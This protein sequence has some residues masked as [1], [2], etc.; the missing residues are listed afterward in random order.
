MHVQKIIKKHRT[1]NTALNDLQ[2]VKKNHPCKQGFNP[3][4]D[5]GGIFT[6]PNELSQISK[7]LRRP[8]ACDFLYVTKI[9]PR[10]P[11]KI[12]A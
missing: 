7:K 6:P 4:L 12:S 5:G 8:K 1:C 2:I 10:H 9:S 3:I 11:V